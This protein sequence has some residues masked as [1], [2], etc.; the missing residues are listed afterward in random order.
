MSETREYHKNRYVGRQGVGSKKPRWKKTSGAFQGD[1]YFYL[2]R[3]K[4]C[5]AVPPI[6]G[7][8]LFIFIS[9]AGREIIILF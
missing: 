8:R 2:M 3:L 1:D 9:S 4:T 7:V 6:V 5:S